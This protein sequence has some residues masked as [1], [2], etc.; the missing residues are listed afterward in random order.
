MM[1][2]P[3]PLGMFIIG[4]KSFTLSKDTFSTCLLASSNS[5]STSFTSASIPVNA[6][7]FSGVHIITQRKCIFFLF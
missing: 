2:S 1:S 3:A 7:N 4:F 6:Y 5:F